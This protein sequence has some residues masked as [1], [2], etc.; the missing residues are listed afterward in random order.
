[1]IK[2]YGLHHNGPE[3]LRLFKGMCAHGVKPDATTFTCRLTA[4]SRTNM[5][6]VGREMFRIMSDDYGIAPTEDHVFCLVDLLARSGE[7]REAGKYLD[8]VP[9]SPS[10]Q[11][12]ATVLSACSTYHQEKKDGV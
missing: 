2:G 8:C 4:C 3:A 11:M 9:C 1:M 10:E 6:V 7:L 12:R 5:I